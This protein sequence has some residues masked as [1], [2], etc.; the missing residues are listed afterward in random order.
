MRRSLLLAP[1]FLLCLLGVSFASDPIGIYALIDK[2][3]LEPSEGNPQRIQIWGAFALAD[4]ADRNAYSQP[5]RGYL[6]YTLPGQKNDVALA[7]W[8]DLKASAGTGQIIAFASRYSPTGRVRTGA[9][10]SGTV[11]FHESRVEGLIKQLDE[12]DQAT[13]DAASAH[14]RRV[15]LAAVPQI[16]AALGKTPSPEVK[17]RLEKILADL[18]P[19]PYPIGFGLVRVRPD[20]SYEPVKALRHFPSNLSPADDGLVEP[21]K[22]KLVAGNAIDA[23]RSDYKFE[24]ESSDGQ[25]ESSGA[26]QQGEKQT[27]WTPKMEIKPGVKYTWKVWVET[28][29]G[30]APVATASFRGK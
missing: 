25:H 9:A 5:V 11:A 26:I 12:Q 30:R 23:A 29:Q 17:T 4:R 19:D 20:R 22:I 24:I 2:V 16:Q 3:V 6:Y 13:R 18:E 15:G 8:K 1:I 7:E 10:P 28:N 27:E 21:G 14:L